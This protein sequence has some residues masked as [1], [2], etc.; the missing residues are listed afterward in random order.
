MRVI[1]PALLLLVVPV[2]VSAHH[3]RA[4]FATLTEEIRGEILAARW[5]NPHPEITLRTRTDDGTEETL[6]I[7]VY[8]AA[9]NLR[10]AGVTDALFSMGDEVT[11]A[12][13]R[14][15]RRPN[16][17]LGTHMLLD[18][19]RQAVFSRTLEP[20]WSVAAVGGLE[21]YLAGG[22]GLADALT[23]NRGLFRMWSMSVVKQMGLIWF[24]AKR[25]FCSSI[26]YYAARR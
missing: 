13:N 11:I 7:Q 5:T 21:D 26:S 20:Y 4:E 19:G 16:F 17:I 8:G 2:I 6:T 25:V 18:D 23:E 9:N 24:Q 12:G 22:S 14:S 10:Q 3:S 1:F 15:T